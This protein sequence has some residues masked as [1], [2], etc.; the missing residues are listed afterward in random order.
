M[1][2]KQL[3]ALRQ[4]RLS[5]KPKLDQPK[6]KTSSRLWLTG[7]VS[8]DQA[9]A[10]ASVSQTLNCVKALLF[11]SPPRRGRSGLPVGSPHAAVL[12]TE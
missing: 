4:L 1:E 12:A 2:P 7:G 6:V 11:P 9:P 10:S 5:L 3:R 8:V